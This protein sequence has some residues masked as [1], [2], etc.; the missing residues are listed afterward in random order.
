LTDAV[1]YREPKIEKIFYSISEVA[2]MLGV[3]PSLIRF[4]DKEFSVLKLQ[5]NKKGNR[6]FTQ[7]DI[8]QLRLIYHLVKE[9]GM[10]LKG[11]AQ[12]LDKN[13]EGTAKTAEVIEKLLM[14]RQQLVDIRNEMAENETENNTE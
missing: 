14:I 10:T 2:V 9:K 11:A 1:P 8:R 3:N 5:K 7:D 13:R 4:W 6:L 12:L